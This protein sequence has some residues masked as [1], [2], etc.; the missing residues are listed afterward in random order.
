MAVPGDEFAEE[1]PTGQGRSREQH[2]QQA[3][4]E[5]T[6]SSSAVDAKV[7]ALEERIIEFTSKDD[8]R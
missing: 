4:K 8:Y 1:G 7:A 2:L 3:S 5:G 6:L